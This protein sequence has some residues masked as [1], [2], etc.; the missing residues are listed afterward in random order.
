VLVVITHHFGDPRQWPAEESWFMPS[1]GL[2]QMNLAGFDK[3]LS[4]TGN[5][6]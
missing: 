5:T 2:K 3:G 6:Q 4:R 1:F